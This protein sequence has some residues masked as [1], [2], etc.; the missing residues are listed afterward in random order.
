MHVVQMLKCIRQLDQV[1]NAFASV[2]SPISDETILECMIDGLKERNVFVGWILDKDSQLRFEA[3]IPVSFRELVFDDYGAEKRFRVM[4]SSYE[5]HTESSH[6]LEFDTEEELTNIMRFDVSCIMFNIQ[7]VIEEKSLWFSDAIKSILKTHS[8]FV[9]AK[10]ELIKYNSLLID[11]TGSATTCPSMNVRLDDENMIHID[12]RFNEEMDDGTNT[13]HEVHRDLNISNLMDVVF[14]MEQMRTI[15][16][17][18][19]KSVEYIPLPGFNMWYMTKILNGYRNAE[20]VDDSGQVLCNTM[21]KGFFTIF[22]NKAEKDD[23]GGVYFH[24]KRSFSFKHMNPKNPDEV[25]DVVIRNYKFP[26]VNAKMTY[27]T[28]DEHGYIFRVSHG[29]RD[30][31]QRTDNERVSRRNAE[32]HIK[33]R[34]DFVMNGFLRGHDSPVGLMHEKMQEKG[35]FCDRFWEFTFD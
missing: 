17:T 3:C 10:A 7:R 1:L 29:W 21:K 6:S 12:S 33:H 13:V 32:G 9:N 5:Y 24:L 34:L 31:P 8:I 16:D 18:P 2:D 20:N 14:A 28:G 30:K 22:E 23:Q 27:D 35:V 25:V 26:F 19:I 15:L 4:L 11:W